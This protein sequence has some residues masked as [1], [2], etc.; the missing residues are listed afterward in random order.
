MF[1]PRCTI[2][3]GAQMVSPDTTT[4]PSTLFS[5]SCGQHG[6]H[7]IGVGVGHELRLKR[8]RKIWCFDGEEIL[9]HRRYL[10]SYLVCNFTY[11]V[12]SYELKYA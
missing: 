1:R 7:Y 10:L 9:G 4:C 8:Q 11:I 5:G 3:V 12:K 2:R 6:G